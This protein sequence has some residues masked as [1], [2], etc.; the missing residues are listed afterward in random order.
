[1][2]TDANI[3]TRSVLIILISILVFPELQERLTLREVSSKG[4][5]PLLACLGVLIEAFILCTSFPLFK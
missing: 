4:D 1:M 3:L 2:F 5:I